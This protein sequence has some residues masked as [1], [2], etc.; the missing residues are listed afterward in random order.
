MKIKI[1]IIG[2]HDFCKKIELLVA[3]RQDIEFHWYEYSEPKA[4]P[5][6]LQ[7]LKPCDAILF[8]GSLP[9][10]YAKERLVD[11]S[12]PV[13]YLKQDET[14]IAITLLHIIAKEH[15]DLHRISIDVREKS[16]IDNVLNDL[17]EVLE[18]PF[19]HTLNDDDK[20]QDIVTYHKLLSME[21]KTDIA[22]TSVHAV[23]EQLQQ[24]QIVAYKMMDSE[25]TILRTIETARQQAILQKSNASQ[26]AVGLIKVIP[27]PHNLKTSIE[28]MATIMKAQLNEHNGEY[29]L[30]TT[31]GNIEFSLKN[32]EFLKLFQSFDKEAKMAF[33]CGE[34][35]VDA[36]E[37]ARFALNL[38]HE[39]DAHSFYILDANKKLHGPFPQTNTAISMKINEPVLV[40]MADKTK[41]SP[42][43]ISKLLQFSQSRHAKQFTATDLALH[44]NV[45]RRTAERTLKKMVEFNY[46]TIVGE[47]M[48]YRQGRPRA[49][50]EFNFPTIY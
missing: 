40:E 4:A 48:T 5:S 32:N 27:R 45:T 36:T 17:N 49:L 10:L 23:Y 38:I 16:L 28:K 24:Q 44:L 46:I 11:F 33:G 41:L 22:I 19:I 29:K 12:I 6:L 42:A 3:N 20:L 35:I 50:Y 34:T 31:M 18:L 37:N 47:E 14:A 9:Y 2:S 26:I 13:L 30:F 43:N 1:A 15:V 25:S 7:S 39:S 8:S 21:G